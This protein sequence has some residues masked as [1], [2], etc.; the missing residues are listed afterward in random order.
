MS[1]GFHTGPQFLLSGGPLEQ[2]EGAP[3]DSPSQDA[4]GGSTEAETSES[5]EA[6]DREPDPQA[7]PEASK[8]YELAVKA[9]KKA[10]KA[11]KDIPESDLIKQLFAQAQ[12]D[13][14]LGE[15]L[16][17][18]SERQDEA[19]LKEAC[20]AFLDARKRFR[21]AKERLFPYSMVR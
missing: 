8:L 15:T 9:K 20:D 21:K 19:L 18:R 5:A 13:F 16:L 4:S 3:A 7:A 11:R 17:A 12:E 14:T 6:S 1:A 10:D 2:D